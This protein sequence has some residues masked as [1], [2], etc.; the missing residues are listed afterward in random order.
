[1]TR[2]NSHRRLY[3]GAARPPWAGAA[4]STS[5]RRAT[6][7]NREV[8]S[9]ELSGLVIPVSLASPGGSHTFGKGLGFPDL[10]EQMPDVHPDL[11]KNWVRLEHVL[12]QAAAGTMGWNGPRSP[13]RVST[14]GAPETV[15]HLVATRQVVKS[16]DGQTSGPRRGDAISGEIRKMFAVRDVSGS[17]LRFESAGSSANF[18]VTPSSLHWSRDPRTL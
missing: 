7:S 14:S 2:V 12:S 13:Q 17:Q 9:T 5:S 6:T 3:G 8:H 18:E 15:L 4:K 11:W 1:M 16:R 10:G